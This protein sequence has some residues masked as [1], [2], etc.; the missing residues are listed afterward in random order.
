MEDFSTTNPIT[1]ATI[2]SENRSIIASRRGSTTVL[3]VAANAEGDAY[4]TEM[5]LALALELGLGILEIG[6]WSRT[7]SR[8][9]CSNAAFL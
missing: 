8:S 9:S 6:F 7:R 4:V 3:D 1:E 5:A 2:E